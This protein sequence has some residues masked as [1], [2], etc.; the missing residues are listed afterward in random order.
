MVLYLF[1]FIDINLCIKI[2]EFVP[3]QKAEENL[4]CRFKIMLTQQPN[5][6]HSLRLCCVV[7]DNKVPQLPK[8]LN[9]RRCLCMPVEAHQG[10]SSA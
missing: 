8:T 2:Q 10:P 3:S 9:N 1:S 7:F 4:M 6:Q 5:L